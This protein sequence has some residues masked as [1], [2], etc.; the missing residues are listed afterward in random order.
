MFDQFLGIVKLEEIGLG[1]FLKEAEIRKAFKGLYSFWMLVPEN[2]QKVNWGRPG[3][4]LT[5][6]TGTWRIDVAPAWPPQCP[7]EG[8]M[9][10]WGGDRGQPGEWC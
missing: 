3:D 9:L 2:F 5:F 6:R 1:H 4:I 8:Q 10:E 7:G